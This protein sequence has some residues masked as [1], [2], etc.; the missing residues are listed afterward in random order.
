MI[1]YSFLYNFKLFI[2]CRINQRWLFLSIIDIEMGNSTIQDVCKYVDMVDSIQPTT[3][4]ID[5]FYKAL[6]FYN[7]KMNLKPGRRSQTQDEAT[8]IQLISDLRNSGIIVG[9]NKMYA[10]S[11]NY[12]KVGVSWDGIRKIYEKCEWLN[13]PPKR[14]AQP[15]QRCRYQAVYP[16]QIWISIFGVIDDR[17]RFLIGLFFNRMEKSKDYGKVWKK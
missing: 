17:S 5:T 13:A 7:I 15:Q 11:R 1:K 10:I 6:S 9:A 2:Y 14:K 3:I 16:N 8:V 4:I 12:P